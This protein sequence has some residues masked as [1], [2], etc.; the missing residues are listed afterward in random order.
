MKTQ[1]P[2][3]TNS[4]RDTL[5]EVMQTEIQ[6]LPELLEKLPPSER[7]NVLCKLMPFVFPKVE[8]VHSKEGEPLT[9]D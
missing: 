7:L 3:L 9:W 5:K 6:K 4:L 8:A 2:I 1:N